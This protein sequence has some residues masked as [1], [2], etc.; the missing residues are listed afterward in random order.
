[1]SC[2]YSKFYIIM[3]P[4]G[5]ENGNQDKPLD[6]STPSQLVRTFMQF[7]YDH[8]CVVHTVVCDS[9]CPG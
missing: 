5:S 7:A 6:Q 2:V 1:M 9:T 8:I 4:S 3:R